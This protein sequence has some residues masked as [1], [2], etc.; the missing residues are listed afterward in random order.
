MLLSLVYSLQCSVKD[1]IACPNDMCCNKNGECGFG[2]NFCAST[3][4]DS[5][6]IVGTLNPARKD[7]RCGVNF[8]NTGCDS[9]ECC[10]VYGWCGKTNGHCL[11]R[12]CQNGCPDDENP[13]DLTAPRADERCGVNFDNSACK[14]GKCCS[15]YGYCGSTFAHCGPDNCQNT[16]DYPKQ[17][18]SCEAIEALAVNLQL[19]RIHPVVFNNI[20]RYCCRVSGITCN[21]EKVV[22]NINWSTLR[23]NGTLSPLPEGLISVDIL[24]N[25]EDEVALPEVLPKSLTALLIQKKA[26]PSRHKP[27]FQPFPDYS[28]SN[29]E[30]LHLIRYQLKSPFNTARLPSSLETLGLDKTELKGSFPDFSAL[31]N[32]TSI[33]ME[34]NDFVGQLEDFPPQLISFYVVDSDVF[35]GFPKNLPATVKEFGLI[36][37]GLNLTIPSA[38]IPPQLEVLYLTDND[39]SGPVPA[40]PLTLNTL[41]LGGNKFTGAVKIEKPLFLTI[42]RN[43]ISDVFVADPFS[44][45]SCDISKNPLQ[46]KAS[47]KILDGK[48]VAN[49]LF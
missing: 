39:I 6:C 37:A 49:G 10:S 28:N 30:I 42:D 44:L 1:G 15:K 21:S 16:C 12:N 17:G 22:T 2:A 34:R 33:Y 35:G 13:I 41:Y 3:T 32:L 7:D 36:R 5:Q 43:K 20:Q 18:E 26:Y 31:V 46:G 38:F 9:G 47:I 23:M 24:L 4:C 14:P 40:F 29:L 27:L 25:E 45:I 8:G 11:K 19:D 48:C